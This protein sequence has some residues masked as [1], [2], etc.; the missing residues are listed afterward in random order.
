MTDNGRV[1]DTR[2]AGYWSDEDLYQ[3]AMEAADVAF[4]R[5]G[6][7]WAYW[8]RAGGPFFVLRFGWNT[9]GRERLT[10][11]LREQLSGTWR[12]EGS[13]TRHDVT[14]HSAR[15]EQI[16]VTYQIMPGNTL[17]GEPAT[18][19]ELGKRLRLSTIGDRFALKRQL[20]DG[21][22][23]PVSSRTPELPGDS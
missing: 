10:L 9:C 20:G 17:S 6:T 14:S 13:S 12:L 2:L 23:D 19:L 8:S 1:L 7:G 15:D 16:V 3:G 18:L 21:E 11:R 5:D 4:R 22:H